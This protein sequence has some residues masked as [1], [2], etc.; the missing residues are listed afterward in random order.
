MYVERDRSAYMNAF[1]HPSTTGFGAKYVIRRED[2]HLQERW[3]KMELLIDLDKNMYTLFIDNRNQ[4]VTGPH[5]VGIKHLNFY[6]N[7]LA[8][9][10]VDNICF[11]MEED[12]ATE[13][14]RLQFPSKEVFTNVS[15]PS[16]SNTNNKRIEDSYQIFPNPTSGLLN[17]RYL[18][19]GEEERT[20]RIYDASG[21]VIK[22]IR[23]QATENTSS[24]IDLSRV[25]SG[26]YWVSITGKTSSYQQK[27][28]VSH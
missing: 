14:S 21:K 11:Q 7:P 3:I 18:A 12:K 19:S 28:I 6:A 5:L 24:Q 20:L 16:I 4:L 22:A 10:Y 15:Q 9:F 8:K 27:I 13:N 25:P 23:M 2:H 17:I 26:L 1:G